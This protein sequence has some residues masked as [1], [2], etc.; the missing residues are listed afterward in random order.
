MCL[1]E[2]RSL[3]ATKSNGNQGTSVAQQHELNIAIQKLNKY[4]ENV[5]N[6]AFSVAHR[7]Q[8]R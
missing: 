3:C 8:S 4:S 1:E 6:I 2:C 5:L 7:D